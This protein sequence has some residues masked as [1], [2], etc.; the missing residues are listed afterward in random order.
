MWSDS[1]GRNKKR[2]SAIQDQSRTV[3]L[4]EKRSRCRV[5]V[6][7]SLRLSRVATGCVRS[8]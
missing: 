1:V 7:V 5:A 3:R 2:L 6:Q 4:N 8:V